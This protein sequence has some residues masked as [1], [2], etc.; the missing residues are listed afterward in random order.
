MNAVPEDADVHL[1]PMR[2]AARCEMSTLSCTPGENLF[3]YQFLN[4]CTC[5][6]TCTLCVQVLCWHAR[7][8]RSGERGSHHLRSV[9]IL[10]LNCVTTIALAQRTCTTPCCCATSYIAT[11]K[12]PACV[13]GLAPIS[14]KY[15]TP[16]ILV[17]CNRAKSH[18]QTD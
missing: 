10:L 11:T 2:H 6:C 12:Q 9:S 16:T 14:K 3:L 13:T 18:G 15:T 17:L 8:F 4:A 5:I 7:D 1:Q